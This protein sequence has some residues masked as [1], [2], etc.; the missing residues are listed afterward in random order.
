MNHYSFVYIVVSLISVTFTNIL[1]ESISFS[2]RINIGYLVSVGTLCFVAL[3]E[4]YWE[5]FPLDLAYKLNL[6]CVAVVAFGCTLQQSSYYGYTSMLP[7]RYTQAVMTG[8]SA[9]GLIVSINRI[10]T[11]SLLEDERINTLFFFSISIAIILVCIVIH[12]LLQRTAFVKFYLEM[13]SMSSSSSFHNEGLFAAATVTNGSKCYRNLNN[14]ESSESTFPEGFGKED[15]GLVD[16]NDSVDVVPPNQRDS[17]VYGSTESR[18]RFNIHRHNFL[19]RGSDRRNSKRGNNAKRFSTGND[20]SS[21]NQFTHSD[22][23]EFDMP[24]GIDDEDLENYQPPRVIGPGSSQQPLVRTTN[25]V[26][27]NFR[28]KSGSST[29]EKESNASK[30]KELC[31]NLDDAFEE[32]DVTSDP[33]TSAAQSN[34]PNLNNLNIET[35]EEEDEGN[36]FMTISSINECIN[37]STNYGYFSHF[38]RNPNA[39]VSNCWNGF[40]LFCRRTY[41]RAR[42]NF[43]SKLDSRIQVVTL[44]WPFMVSIFLAYLVTLSLFPGI[45]TEIISCDFKSWMPVLLMFTFNL[46][47]FLGKILSSF[48]YSIQPLNLMFLT[49]LRIF[50][51]PLL[52]FCVAPRT[53]PWFSHESW[54]FMFTSIL[55]ISNGVCGSLPMIIASTRVPSDLKEITGNLMTMTYSIGLTTGSLLAYLLEFGLNQSETAKNVTEIVC[56]ASPNLI[57]YHFVDISSQAN[58]A[59]IFVSNSTF[60]FIPPTV[61]NINLTKL[62]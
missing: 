50:L 19:R 17:A 29:S 37:P 26:K 8:E 58:N 12:N 35:T 36:I 15:L 7:T 3:I 56:N 51:L 25:E 4:I 34:N 30:V 40:C 52:F 48:F 61:S 53:H 16:M 44:T 2:W 5:S 13:C 60:H 59:S 18:S 41:F 38:P 20:S 33:E 45:E 9:A 57:H 10:L 54:S 14:D 62:F 22:S 49:S 55:G 42:S 47:D 28:R 11:K 43:V 31:F 46:T 6:L 27:A 1:V 32:I 21:E 24:F 39:I 23:T